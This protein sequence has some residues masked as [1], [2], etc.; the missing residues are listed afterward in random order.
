MFIKQF[1]DEG[2]GNSSFLIASEETGLAAVLDPQRD[3]DRYLQVAEGLGLRLVYSLDTHLH[4]DFISGSRELAVQAGV[5]VG[6]SAEAELGFEHLPLQDGQVIQFGDLSIRV[7]ATPGHTPEHISF[8]LTEAEKQIPSALFT[9]GALMVGGAARTDLLG[10]S[11]AEPLA[12]NLYHSI[13]HKLLQFPDD[14]AVYPT[15][16]AG[17]FCAAPAV[18]ERSTTIGRERAWNPLAHTQDEAVFIHRAL[19]DLPSYPTYFKHLRRINQMGPR[20]LGGVPPLNPLQPEAVARAMAQSIAILD[21]RPSKE[22][23]AG[24]IPASFGIPLDAP[25]V[26]WAGWVIP[27][28][29]PLIII[30]DH[31]DQREEATRQLIRIGYDDL[32]GYLEGGIPA[33][34]A[35]GLPVTRV[36]R[37]S[38][39]ELVRRLKRADAPAV[40]DVRFDPEWRAGHIPG[41]I[42]IEPGRLAAEELPVPK[43]HPIVVHCGHSDRSTVGISL[44]ERRGFTNLALLKG[45]ISAWQS[46]GYGLES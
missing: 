27:F 21:I 38:V 16:G 39:E 19:S 46:A 31:P 44:L 35:T 30:A 40:V 25:L 13:H 34:E 45:G 24:H 37:I 26:T 43:D 33:W 20:L 10:D 1:V 4:N 2:L 32:R 36:P 23:A 28:G 15:H 7:L 41:A 22:F 17:S 5:Q 42:H 3:V 18:S 6:A 11:L 9:G 29:M 14:V 8:S 12:H